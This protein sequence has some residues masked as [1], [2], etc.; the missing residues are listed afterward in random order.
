[1]F[2]D[3]IRS[4]R[5]GQIGCNLVLR[6]YVQLPL[7]VIIHA[8][9]TVQDDLVEANIKAE[10]TREIVVVVFH[11]K[12]ASGQD[13]LAALSDSLAVAFQ[14]LPSNGPHQETTTIRM[15]EK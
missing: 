14:P 7:G 5:G 6:V 15:E 12:R 8:K 9:G 2:N 4:N 1:V 11:G 3:G 13:P 10:C